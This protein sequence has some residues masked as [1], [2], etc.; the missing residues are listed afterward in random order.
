MSDEA[1]VKAQLHFDLD[2]DMKR[3]AKRFKNCRLTL[4]VRNPDFED[5]DVFL[6]DDD[7]ETAFA[8]VRKLQGKQSDPQS[9]EIILERIATLLGTHPSGVG[10]AIERLL[11]QTNHLACPNA[12][13]DDRVH[14]IRRSDGIDGPTCRTTCTTCG[15][16]TPM[17]RIILTPEMRERIIEQYTR[18]LRAQC[19]LRGLR[20]LLDQLGVVTSGLLRAVFDAEMGGK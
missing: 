1:A 10:E 17:R 13:S 2:R 8:S 14:R 20:P 19:E 18:E 16:V 4:I 6:T 15:P 9:A 12:G 5:G 11:A 3:I 7:T